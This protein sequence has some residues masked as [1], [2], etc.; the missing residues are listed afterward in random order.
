PFEPTIANTVLM[1]IMHVKS[2][3]LHEVYSLYLVVINAPFRILARSSNLMYMGA[4]ER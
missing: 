3:D 2:V 1:S 4:D